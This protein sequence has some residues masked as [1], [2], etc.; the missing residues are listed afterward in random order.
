MPHAA[1]PG[2]PDAVAAPVGFGT[3]CALEST[4]DQ[5]TTRL[6]FNFGFGC[7]V[8]P[9]QEVYTLVGIKDGRAGR[10]QMLGPVQVEG[11]HGGLGVVEE[12]VLEG[13]QARVV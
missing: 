6:F 11:C 13:R 3:T 12:P 10:L 8:L 7:C 9:C 2:G 1:V 4:F 5:S